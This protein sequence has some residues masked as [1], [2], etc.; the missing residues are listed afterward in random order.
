MTFPNDKWGVPYVAVGSWKQFD[1][2]C[3]FI[4]D[5]IVFMKDILAM[6]GFSLKPNNVVVELG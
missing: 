5:R 4:L 3:N 6:N 1:F 2:T